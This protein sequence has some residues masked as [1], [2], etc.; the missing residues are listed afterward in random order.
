M[1][2]YSKCKDKRKQDE[3]SE[4]ANFAINNLHLVEK[5]NLGERKV[6]KMLMTRK[7][8]G[9]KE[10]LLDCSA[11]AHMFDEQHYFTSYTSV[12]TASQLLGMVCT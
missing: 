8:T 4:S 12:Q 2:E 5:K 11:I 10:L 3:K 7:N 9:G 1:P 6:R